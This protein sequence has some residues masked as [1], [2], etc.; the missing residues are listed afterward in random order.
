[1]EITIIIR[2]VRRISF[3]IGFATYI[4]VIECDVSASSWD[5]MHVYRE[6][7]QDCAD[8]YSSKRDGVQSINYAKMKINLINSSSLVSSSGAACFSDFV[9]NLT[10]MYVSLRTTVDS[11]RFSFLGWDVAG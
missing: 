10:E 3:I 7:C 4:P 6:S 9:L 1:M 2:V 8:S 5:G 11:R